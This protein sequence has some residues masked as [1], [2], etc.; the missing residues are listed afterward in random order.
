MDCLRRRRVSGG[1]STPITVLGRLVSNPEFS[2][3]K[4][5]LRWEAW[6]RLSRSKPRSPFQISRM[7]EIKAWVRLSGIV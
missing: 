6:G 1:E 5:H 3:L 7:Q 4:G 2:G